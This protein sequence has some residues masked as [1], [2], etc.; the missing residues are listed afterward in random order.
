MFLKSVTQDILTERCSSFQIYLF[1]YLFG[2][3]S[4]VFALNCLDQF[5]FIVNADNTQISYIKVSLLIWLLVSF[6]FTFGFSNILVRFI[7]FF[8][9]TYCLFNIDACWT[10]EPKFY[11][12]SSF[13]LIFI[14]I[15]RI[16]FWNSHKI[17]LKSWPIKLL[18]FSQLL[19]FFTGGGF[20][21]LFDTV[22]FNGYGAYYSLMVPWVKPESIG[23]ILNNET[24]LVLL[25]YII[26]ISELFAFVLF[27]FPKTRYMALLIYFS[28]GLFTTFIFRIDLIGPLSLTLS[29]LFSSLYNFRILNKNKI[30]FNNYNGLF[31]KS[32]SLFLK[33][34]KFLSFNIFRNLR[35][36]SFITIS[37]L[38]F[39][40]FSTSLIYN[41]YRQIDFFR[42]LPRIDL[43]FEK[44]ENF[45]KFNLFRELTCI[46]PDGLFTRE[47]FENLTAFKID[48]IS[49]D[50]SVQ[51]PIIVFNDD[52]SAG[53]NTISFLSS[54][55][56]GAFMYDC[57]YFRNILWNWFDESE[58]E[59]PKQ[60]YSM[61]NHVRE[62]TTIPSN[63]IEC[64]RLYIKHITQPNHFQGNVKLWLN[65]PWFN[66]MEFRDSTNSLVLVNE[67]MKENYPETQRLLKDSLGINDLIAK[68]RIYIGSIS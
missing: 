33:L 40:S 57:Q 68:L 46:R 32:S 16:S 62:K 59:I 24:I 67:A 25:N 61:I 7:L 1:R 41:F 22:W 54:R 43:A 52:L 47:H 35:Y 18:F 31:Y 2:T 42:A 51:N 9:S 20:T 19:N 10:I 44:F 26:L 38:I 65:H 17:K 64:V 60:I 63:Q 48:V 53:P 56:Y 27:F 37:I 21:K 12:T 30:R 23:G 5:S 36:L 8:C 50:G 29:L 34:N 55:Y 14:E 58:V 66:V 13:F 3:L 28:F 6:L 15:D 11:V 45:T 4:I 39:Y 49:K